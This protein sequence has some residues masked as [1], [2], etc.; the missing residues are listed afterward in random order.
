MRFLALLLF[1]L[2]AV[3][4]DI[5]SWQTGE[6]MHHEVSLCATKDSAMAVVDADAKG[7]QEAAQE[8]FTARDDCRTLPVLGWSVGKV[9]HSVKAK[10]GAGPVTISVV[11]ILDGD[12][13]V[14]AYFITGL[15][16]VA[17]L[18]VVPNRNS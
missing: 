10:R 1:P 2:S 9:V 11:E 17:K 5:D 7:G 18:A 12:G 8:V 14:L 6:V 16:V 15:P 4:L 3:A 13:K